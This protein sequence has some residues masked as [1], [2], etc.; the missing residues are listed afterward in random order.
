MRIC[1]LGNSHVASLKLGLEKLPGGRQKFT[2]EFFASRAS[3][4]EGLRLEN[5]RL[6]PRNENLARAISHTSGGKREVVLDDYDAFL[7]YGLGFRLP[8]VETQLSAAVQRQA[9]RDTAV[10]TLNFH[11]CS[12]LRQATNKPVYVGH[13]PQEAEGRKR[14]AVNRSLPYGGVYDL[15]KDALRGEDLRLV[16]QP[17]RT[18]ANDWFTRPEFSAGSTRLDIGD[19]KSNELHKDVDNKH[20]NGDFGRIWLEESFFPA[21][22]LKT[23][24]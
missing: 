6:V 18:F 3:A 12:L 10:G 16:Q 2:M 11:L 23:G 15:T 24:A 14:R 1:V 7:V 20:M 22:G 17:R 5:K 9:C 4:M 13:D 21:V 8:V 19:A